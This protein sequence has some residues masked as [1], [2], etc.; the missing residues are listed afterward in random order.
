MKYAALILVVVAAV[1]CSQEHSDNTSADP[2]LVSADQDTVPKTV[3]L[4]G[5]GVRIAVET[6]APVTSVSAEGS[7]HL[8]YELRLTGF[9]P[10][11]LELDSVQVIDTSNHAVLAEYGPHE[12]DEMIVSLAGE[13]KLVLNPGVQSVL[14]LHIS[15]NPATPQPSRIFHRLSFRY[16]RSGQPETL[17]LED[18][19]VRVTTEKI[20]EISPPLRGGPWYAHAGPANNSHHR[21]TLAPR[22]G[23]LTMDQRFATDWLRLEP[24]EGDFH[25]Y[26]KPDWTATLGSEVLSVAAGKVVAVLDG[27]PD[28]EIGDLGGSGLIVDWNTIG[29]NRVAIELDGGLFAWYHHL[30]PGSIRISPGDV[31]SRGQVIGLVGNSGNT[32]HPHLH[33]EI[34]DSDELGKGNGLPYV[35]SC[36]QLKARV[37]PMPDWY[38]VAEHNPDTWLQNEALLLQRAE[39]RTRSDEIPLGGAIV[40]FSDASKACDAAFK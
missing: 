21:R 35:F 9:D 2:T 15:L 5:L 3:P 17:H 12:L 1:G 7:R 32:S 23:K 13:N 24:K 18:E 37:I 38:V 8:F 25:G 27:L 6:I 10:R 28:E 26:T 36:F 39:D 34:T 33:F 40:E 11:P 30:R 22:N 4:P 19:P 20:L 16:T 29:G 14:F 31:V